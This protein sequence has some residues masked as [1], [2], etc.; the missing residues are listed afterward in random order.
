MYHLLFENIFFIFSHDFFTQKF[1][2]SAFKATTNLFKKLFLSKKR[3]IFYTLNSVDFHQILSKIQSG[4]HT[5]NLQLGS[6]RSFLCPDFSLFVLFRHCT[7]YII[8]YTVHHFSMP[9]EQCISL[10]T[11]KYVFFYHFIFHKRVPP[12]RKRMISSCI[13][14]KD[15]LFLYMGL[16]L[17]MH[18][19]P[20]ISR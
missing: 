20:F 2:V 10:L 11:Q 8:R 13:L 17:P 6:E 12:M 3:K 14:I 18:L 5:V 15:K 16:Y 9:F 4:S 1:A 7:I 19:I